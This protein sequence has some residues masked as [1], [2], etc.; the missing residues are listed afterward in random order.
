MSTL[1]HPRG[2]PM[3]TISKVNTVDY[4]ILRAEDPKLYRSRR[5]NT[6][7]HAASSNSNSM[8]QE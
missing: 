7:I 4:H 5:P 2:P 3:H 6:G 1:A 8:C